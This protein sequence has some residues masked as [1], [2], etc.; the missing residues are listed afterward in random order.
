MPSSGVTPLT[1]IHAHVVTAP[2]RRYLASVA[3]HPAAAAQLPWLASSVGYDADRLVADMDR[4]GIGHAWVSSPP[5][6]VASDDPVLARESAAVLNADLLD[7]TSRH[8]SRLRAV[9]LVP[10]SAPAAAADVVAL[11]G[12]AP[13]AMVHLRPEGPQVDDES[14]RPALEQLEQAGV[15]L[16]LH[17]G[18]EPMSPLM[19]PFGLTS[20]LSAPLLTTVAVM[21]LIHSGTLDAFPDLTLV[22]PHA[23]G[24]LPYLL[25]RLEDQS[26]GSAT[27]SVRDY[28][29]RFTFDSACFDDNALR[30]LRSSLPQTDIALGSDAPFRGDLQRA[31]DTYL[32]A[33]L[34]A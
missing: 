4:A 28:L 19:S 33:G 24:V 12:V 16:F 31:V 13:A 5:P 3:A 9:P 23:G 6:G 22:V 30:F 20:A 32:E 26:S 2:Y 14:F 27:A 18:V 29:H 21:R 7:E 34:G 11:P 1:D 25:V 17:P 10:L 15:S 8:P